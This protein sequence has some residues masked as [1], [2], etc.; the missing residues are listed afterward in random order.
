MLRVVAWYVEQSASVAVLVAEVTA[1]TTWCNRASDSGI[2]FMPAHLLA[3]LERYD[4][5]L[6]S[7]VGFL[8]AALLSQKWLYW[9]P[10]IWEANVCPSALLSCLSCTLSVSI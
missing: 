1:V 7:D 9:Q 8:F 4:V 10:L 3:C 6:E 2:A 5:R